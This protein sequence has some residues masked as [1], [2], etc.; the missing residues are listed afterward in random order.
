MSMTSLATISSGLSPCL[1]HGSLSQQGLGTLLV[2]ETFHKIISYIK[3]SLSHLEDLEK[4]VKYSY[5]TTIYL[6]LRQGLS[7]CLELTQ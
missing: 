4:K 3:R 7:F 1:P 6:I 2:Q 5:G